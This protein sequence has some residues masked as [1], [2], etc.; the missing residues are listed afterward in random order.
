MLKTAFFSQ[1]GGQPVPGKKILVADDELYI[2][3]SIALVLEEEGYQVFM[4]TDGEEAL[5][6]ALKETPDLIILD[7]KM[8]KKSGIEVNLRLRE[9][10]QRKNI[11]IIILTAIGKEVPDREGWELNYVDYITKPF[12]PYDIVERVN[13]ILGD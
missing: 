6:L 9:D 11:P 12:S 1:R 8:P 4:A 2:L 3:R 7:I 13:R 10:K 5:R